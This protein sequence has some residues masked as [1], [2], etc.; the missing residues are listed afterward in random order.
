MFNKLRSVIKPVTS[1]FEVTSGICLT[2]LTSLS[3]CLITS[4]LDVSWNT[5]AVDSSVF[6]SGY[7]HK[8]LTYCFIHRDVAQ[9]LVSAGVLVAFSSS[10]ERGVGTVR[11]FY[12]FSLH[13]ILTGLLFSL[14]ALVVFSEEPSA[15]ATNNTASGFIPVALS[16]LGMVTI[17]SRMQRAFLFGVNVPTVVLPWIILLVVTLVVP[18]TVLLCNAVAIVVGVI[19]GKGFLSPL[20][21]SESRATLLEKKTFFRLLRRIPGVQ[22]VPSSA[23]ERREILHARCKPSPGSYPVQAYAPATAASSSFPTH[24]VYEG[25]SHS[26]YAQQ[27]SPAAFPAAPYGFSQGHGHSHGGHGHSHD[28]HGHSHDGHGHSHDGGHGHSH[29]GHS[30]SHGGGYAPSH[31]VPYPGPPAHSQFGHGVGAAAAY[32]HSQ[33]HAGPYPTGG[34]WLPPSIPMPAPPSSGHGSGAPTPQAQTSEPH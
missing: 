3:V 20:E 31:Y 26:S 27:P 21:M 8:L 22:F 16:L 30:H 29:G 28:G 25:W 2:I 15:S 1:S 18:G 11:F 5:L 33:L 4:F 24:S 19:Y 23:E 9:L 12:L 10:L 14:L 17:S 7:V 6:S 34:V 13:A 32:G